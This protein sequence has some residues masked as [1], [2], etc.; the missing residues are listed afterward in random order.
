MRK[1]ITLPLL[2]VTLGITQSLGQTPPT[3]TF[4][5]GTW[6][7][8]DSN[9]ISARGYLPGSLHESLIRSRIIPDP[10]V[11]V[12][13]QKI[14]WVSEKNWVFTSDTFDLK[15]ENWS[16]FEIEGAQLYTN[17]FLN[18]EKIGSSDNSFH[19]V[20]LEARSK[21]QETGNVLKVY[22]NSVNRENR[23]QH[24]MP[25]FLFG[26]DWG[27]TLIDMSV[28][29][30]N[31]VSEKKSISNINLVTSSIVRGIAN[32][33]I[34]WEFN[35]RDDETVVWAISEANGGKVVAKGRTAAKDEQ[36]SF[37]VP[38]ARLWWTNDMGK[39]SMHKLEL[40]VLTPGEGMTDKQETQVGLRTIE[41]DT[42]NGAFRFV[43]NGKP[44]YA[45]GANYI[46]TDVIEVRENKIEE[47][48]LLEYA[49]MANMNMIRVWGGGDY[50]TDSMMDFCDENGILIWH[51]FMFACAMYPGDED[52]LS[53]VKE[54]AEAQTL[55]LRNHPSL[56]LWCGNNEISEGWARWGWKD[57]LSKSEIEENQRAY[58]TIFKEIL[59][60]TVLKNTDTQYWESSPMLG[61]GDKNFKN[62][63]D[64]HDWGIWHD[65]YSFDSLWTRVPRFMSEYGF[66]SFPSNHTF[67]AV[68]TDDSTL[69]RSD[70]RTNP[71]VVNHEKHPR[72][73]D[74]IDSYI[75]MT[76]STFTNE[77]ISL[78]DW[79]YLSR[80]IQAEGIAEGA[81]AGRVN[82]GHN[83]GTLVWQLN[84][85][86]PV[87]S[88]SSVD[89]RGNWKLLHHKLKNAFSPDL[90]NG[91]V[92]GQNLK[93]S[94]V[95][96]RLGNGLATSGELTAEIY[97]L[98]G[99]QKKVVT[100]SLELVSGGV[101]SLTIENIFPKKLNLQNTLIVLTYK[102]GS[103]HLIDYVYAVTAD[104]LDLKA[105]DL[106]VTNLGR[107]GNSYRVK[108][109]SSSFAKC[110]EL[111]AGIDGNFSYN[112]F[113]LL[114]GES[115]IIDFFPH[116]SEFFTPSSLN[117]RAPDKS[118]EFTARCLNGL[119]F[120]ND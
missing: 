83:W 78:E 23:T 54:E 96:D 44:L 72:G 12:N 9:G 37:F 22:F 97:S 46:P 66:Q 40:V 68:L 15:D 106:T 61:R 49:I 115:I 35:G 84:D 2:L 70:F 91:R 52:F 5:T 82:K 76:H 47:T 59:P 85:C 69:Y 8:L 98:D 107:M 104:K 41:L 26:W 105:T 31:L 73:F 71:E 6:T 18:G 58:N 116:K 28:R 14:S 88:W 90:L 63:G 111:D 109:E 29:S 117:V 21:M 89:A 4:F 19:G 112:G 48:R 10:F 94:L 38:N 56:A 114:T 74:I 27:P 33:T 67:A 7:C 30:I 92:E 95:S 110:V 65:G 118:P 113:D 120:P 1:L 32:G 80:V 16:H 3:L 53:K 86:W 81:I 60:K 50:A 102:A 62:V 17:W 42:E 39:P 55:R 57:K 43:L 13:E 103:I 34:S 100:E 20:N 75:D 87:A 99:K 79:A 64:A 25:Q 77:N 51:D 108:V 101:S 45:K 93:V 36:A 119:L 11:G 24:R